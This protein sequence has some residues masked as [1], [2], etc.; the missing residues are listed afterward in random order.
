MFKGER[1][2]T[3]RN[4]G[5]NCFDDDVRYLDGDVTHFTR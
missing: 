3:H 5:V 1:H 2:P 4:G